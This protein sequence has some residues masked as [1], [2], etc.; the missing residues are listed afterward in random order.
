MK[1]PATSVRHG[2]GVRPFRFLFKRRA[3][4]YHAIFAEFGGHLEISAIHRVADV[5]N[6]APCSNKPTPRHRHRRPRQSAGR[7]FLTTRSLSGSPNILECWGKAPFSPRYPMARNRRRGRNLLGRP[8][9]GNVKQNPPDIA[10]APCACIEP[11]LRHA[12]AC[13][14]CSER[15]A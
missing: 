9:V 5:Q 6:T 14:I 10:R 2:G 15:Q 12:R 4:Q 3:I 11:L 13:S 8:V 7:H 1:S